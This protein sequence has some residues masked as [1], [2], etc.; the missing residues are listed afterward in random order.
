MIWVYLKILSF[1]R[2]LVVGW[3]TLWYVTKKWQVRR[4]L[5]INYFLSL[6]ILEKLFRKNSI[7]SQRAG[8]PR[9]TLSSHLESPLTPCYRPQ[10]RLWEGYVFTGVCDSVHRGVCLIECWD[11]PP[12]PE[13][14]T[15]RSRHPIGPEAVTP[16]A[17]TPPRARGRHPSGTRGRHPPR[18]SACWRYGQQ[19]GG[20][21]PT[22][23]QS[24]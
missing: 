11:T 16:P 17:D 15:P 19:A 4:I 14:G 23:M 12:G 22:G 7:V 6:I 9:S 2:I 1:K 3:L 8:P 5:L 10:T 18:S 13:T 20:T 21:H 24:C